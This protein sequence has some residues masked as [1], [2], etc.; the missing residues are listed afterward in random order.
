MKYTSS[1]A[2]VLLASSDVDAIRIG[3][4][5]DVFGPNGDGYQNSLPNYDLA[6][7]GIDILKKG[8]GPKCT[9]RDWAKAHWVGTLADGRVVTDSVQEGLGYPKV[10]SVGSHEVFSCWDIAITQLHEGDKVKLSCPAFYVWGS[11]AMISPLGGTPIPRNSDVDFELDIIECAKIPE[12]DGRQYFPQPHTTTMQGN[13]PFYLHSH[14]GKDT[15]NDWVLSSKSVGGKQ[16][17]NVEHKVD[18]EKEQMWFWNEKT[19]GLHNA[20]HPDLLLDASNGFENVVLAKKNSTEKLQGKFD[21][22]EGD[23]FLTANKLPLTVNQEDWTVRTTSDYKNNNQF[24][25]LEYVHGTFSQ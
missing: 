4:A 13:I 11:A 23:Q 17:V 6:N 9:K 8:N 18:S 7:I 14:L 25:H 16:I 12:R 19:G 2:A 15:A 3:A 1:I 20:A 22:N 10:W 24:W 5:P 21:Y